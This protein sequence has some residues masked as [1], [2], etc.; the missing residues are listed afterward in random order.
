MVQEG[1]FRA[2]LFYRLNVFPVMLPPLRERRAD[3]PDLVRFFA[4]KYAKQMN[5]PIETIPSDAMHA[6][7]RYDW[8]GNIRELQNFI[9][10]AVILS[11]GTVLQPPIAELKVAPAP[12]ASTPSTARTSNSLDDA[13]REHIVQVL[14]EARWVLGGSN[15]AAARMGIPRTTLIYKMRRL[16]IRPQQSDQRS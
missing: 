5:K 14:R 15:G 6:L 16:G 9:E 12:A 10:R 3:I 1:Q 13:Q 7:A 2:D 11:K 8:P 4:E